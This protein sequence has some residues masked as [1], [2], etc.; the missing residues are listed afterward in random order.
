MSVELVDRQGNVVSI[1]EEEAPARIASGELGFVAG[2]PVHVVGEDGTV[3]TVAPEQAHAALASG[4]RLATTEEVRV[5][6]LEARHGGIGGTLAATGEGIGRGLTLG[7][8]DYLAPKIAGALGGQEAER[9]ARTHLEEEQESHPY[10]AGAGELLGAVAPVIASGGAAA[11]EEAG[12]LGARAAAGQAVRTLGV[13][14]RAIDAAGGFAEGVAAKLVGTQAEGVLGKA[15]QTAVRQAA[16]G[17]VEGGIWEAGTD[18]SDSNLHDEPLVAD[19]LLAHIGHG[20]LLTGAV[21]ASLGAFGALG[22]KALERAADVAEGPIAELADEQMIRTIS[23]NKK[24]LITEAKERFGSMKPV[25]DRMRTDIGVEA[26]DALEDIAKKAAKADASAIAGLQES[27]EKV[28]AEGVNL[29]DLLRSL[30]KRKAEFD[31]TLGHEAAA[32]AVQKQIDNLERIYADR[33]E[34][35]GRKAGGAFDIGLAP[36]EERAVRGKRAIEIEHRNEPFAIDPNAGLTESGETGWRIDEHGDPIPHFG[37]EEQPLKF[38]FTRKGHIAEPSHIDEAMTEGADVGRGGIG[39]RDA[40]DV[41]GLKD[42]VFAEGPGAARNPIRIH[43]NSAETAKL[44][45]AAKDDVTIPLKTLLDQRRALE[46]T[47]NWQTDSVVA[48]GR[49]AAGRTIEDAITSAGDEAAA[50]SGADA[51][52]WRQEYQEAKR[53]FSEVRWIKDAADDALDAKLRNRKVSPSD[54]IAG[55]AGLAGGVSHGILG[56]ISGAALGAV[57]HVIRE[58]GNSTA[59]VLLDRLATYDG[60]SQAT[61]DMSEQVSSAITAALHT[62]ASRASKDDLSEARYTKEHARLSDLASMTPAALRQHLAEQTTQIAAHAPT[63]AKAVQDKGVAATNYLTAKLPPPLPSPT[64]TPQL[65]KPAQVSASTRADLLRAVDAVNGGPPFILRKLANGTMTMADADVLR[66]V[67]PDWYPKI[68][69][70]VMQKCAERKTP[71][72]LQTAMRLGLLFDLPTC[73][74]LDPS[75]LQAQAASAPKQRAPGGDGAPT[76]GRGRP[77]AKID[78]GDSHRS[79]FAGAQTE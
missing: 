28:G 73:P 24:S 50:K 1:S 48:Q 9:A 68:Q 78:V 75:F 57:H 4:A 62:K 70:E 6:Q 59:A 34:R 64:L 41:V 18:V 30:G 25:A 26:G 36:S 32:D 2:A 47:I 8:S 52:T 51:G 63:L 54:Y 35:A 65:A 72:P 67:Y 66:K 44:I 7:A 60:I 37:E 3:G 56:G 31:R 23:A 29:K 74:E 42:D 21:G 15:A 46:G 38:D 13:I 19:Q 55:A 27:V 53:R 12:A 76:K 16:R 40:Y 10:A 11:A 14:P 5:A 71:L 43:K 17:I 33:V 61:R 45:Q 20:A 58:R 39:T 49:K 79:E 22:S 77:S 69:Q